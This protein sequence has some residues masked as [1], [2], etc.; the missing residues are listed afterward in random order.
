MM[1]V[2]MKYLRNAWYAGALSTEL[3]SGPVSRELLGDRM[4]LF[5]SE[6]GRTAA[7]SD[8]CPHRFAPL[9]LGRVAGEHIECGYH[10]LRFD[11]SGKCVLNPHGDKRISPRAE[12]GSWPTRERYGFVWFWP[13]DPKLADDASIPPYPFNA[14]PD[15]FAVVYGHIDVAAHYELV[16]DNLLDLSHVEFL[17]PLFK[18]SGG[19]DSHQMSYGVEGTTVI[20]NR[21]KPNVEIQGL[22]RFFWTSPS[23]RF[24][25][26]SNMR[27]LPPSA[28]I[29]DLGGTECGAPVEEGVCLPNAHL[30]PPASEFCCH[31]FWSIA[32][33]RQIDDEESGRGL[34][35]ITQKVFT[36]EDIPM[37]EAQQRNIGQVTDILSLR[38]LTLE[39]DT[40]AVR[41][42]L[43][44]ADLIRRETDAQAAAAE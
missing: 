35:Q 11:G 40:P 28:L 19:V 32:R 29:F 30:I 24:D 17:H 36:T 44:L 5:R 18:Q 2:K 42:R 9:S 15:R 25:A 3:D 23:K 10:G 8:R 14:D 26:R 6:S 22:A 21:L 34:Q 37:I 4:V 1:G 16:V 33:N 43:I 7:L 12:V 38:P 13:G 31:Y 39:P 41:A 27:W 20:A